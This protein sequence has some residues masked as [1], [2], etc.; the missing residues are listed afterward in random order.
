MNRGNIS[1]LIRKFRLLKTADY[2][3]FQILRAKNL[4]KNRVYI[5]NHPNV[6]FPPDYLLYESFAIDY[7]A[8]FE[9]G[10]ITADDLFKFLTKYKTHK[11]LNILDWGCGP[12]R[13]IR[14]MPQLF[15]S[16]CR[17]Y[18][19]DYNSKSI[20]WCS[21]NIPNVNFTVND[22]SPPLNYQNHFFDII[23]GISIITHLSRKMQF[24]WIKEFHRVLN[25]D[26]LMLLTSAGNSFQSILTKEEKAR[27]Q[28][29]D[30]VIRSRVK[31]GHRTYTAFHP[32]RFM[33]DLFAEFEIL[34][35]I[36]QK[37][38]GM[39][40]SQDIWIIRKLPPRTS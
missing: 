38:S 8:Y 39:N 11:D 3:R 33:Q 17:F 36:E 35:H 28:N 26:G 5:K 16:S 20:N 9:G 29:G 12:G 32:V 40:L 23:Y 18:G 30:L 22:L 27:F 25:K 31:E 24:D 4:S 19:T 7:R 2:L 1:N 37:P 6:S 34:E 15:D 21:R 10:K 13:I 14:H